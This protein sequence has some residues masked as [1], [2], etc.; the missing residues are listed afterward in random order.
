MG[1]YKLCNHRK[2]ERD[3]CDHQWWGS[4]RGLRVSLNRWA[5]RDINTKAEAYARSMN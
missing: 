2:R 3:R 1:L 5:N 4:F